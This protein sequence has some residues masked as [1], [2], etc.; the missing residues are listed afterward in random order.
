M[1][2]LYWSF[3]EWSDSQVTC[4]RYDSFLIHKK[5]SWSTGTITLCHYLKLELSRKLLNKLKW[6]VI[7][8]STLK[9]LSFLQYVWNENIPQEFANISNS[10]S[11]NTCILQLLCYFYSGIWSH[12]TYLHNRNL[13]QISQEKCNMRPNEQYTYPEMSLQTTRLILYI[14][15]NQSSQ[16]NVSLWLCHFIGYQMQNKSQLVMTGPDGAIYG[17]VSVSIKVS[18]FAEKKY[19]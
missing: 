14:Q 6:Y 3:V 17:S 2:F 11:V 1:Y 15:V 10:K 5:Q 4:P 7:P 9:L 18:A 13:Q 19:L 8:F 16:V 12:S